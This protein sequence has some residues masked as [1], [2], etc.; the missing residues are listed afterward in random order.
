MLGTEQ[1]VLN[2]STVRQQTFHRQIHR[3]ALIH[4]VQLRFRCGNRLHLRDNTPLVI[5]KADTQV[6]LVRTCVFFECFHQRQDRIAC[7]GINVLE[8]GVVLLDWVIHRVQ[9]QTL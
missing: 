1:Q 9:I 7:I 6:N 3:R 4:A 8:H 5:V 2:G